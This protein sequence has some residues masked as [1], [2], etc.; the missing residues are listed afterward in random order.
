MKNLKG[1]S[2]EGSIMA[3][4]MLSPTR[5]SYNSTINESVMKS[6]HEKP[7]LKKDNIELMKKIKNRSKIFPLKN[8][9]FEH[10]SDK[11]E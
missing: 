7:V 10:S 4:P 11:A 3:S 1:R 9:I 2:K 8:R 5:Q 6:F